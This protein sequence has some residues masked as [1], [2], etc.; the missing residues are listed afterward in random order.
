MN[1]KIS[2]VLVGFSN[3]THID[4]AVGCSGATG[5]SD[6]QMAR[7]QQLWQTDFGRINA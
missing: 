1:P 3:T 6:D 5:L 4:E 7:L 2:T